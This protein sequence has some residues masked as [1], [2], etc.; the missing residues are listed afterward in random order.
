MSVLNKKM[1]QREKSI[2]KK[3]GYDSQTLQTPIF[4]EYGNF[5]KEPNKYI[6]RGIIAG[7]IFLIL[8]LLLY[9]PSWIYPKEKQTASLTTDTL[10][11][12]NMTNY[13]K[14]YP[15]ED[16]DQDGLINVMEEENETSPR[17]P[18]TDRDGLSDYAECY[19]TFTNPKK[20]DNY[21]DKQMEEKLSQEQTSVKNPFRVGNIILWAKD[22]SSR[23]HGSVVKTYN[24]YRFC[25]FKGYAEFPG[26]TVYA[27]K[28]IGEKHIPLKYKE[29][30]KAWEITDDSEVRIYDHKLEPIYKL[31]FVKKY[32][33]ISNKYIGTILSFL[34]P[35]KS[36]FLSCE[37][38]M[39]EDTY[40]NAEGSVENEIVKI[41]YDETSD[42]RFGRAFYTLE[43]L[44]NI[45][46]QIDEGR[47]LL[48]SLLS[49]SLG[50]GIIEIYGYTE[51]GD[52]LIA[53][54]QELKPIGTLAITE[55]TGQ[56]MDESGTVTVRN[57]FDFE[58]FGFNSVNGNVLSI[59]QASVIPS[60]NNAIL[61]HP[62]SKSIMTGE[63]YEGT[64]KADGEPE[65]YAWYFKLE[66]K[67]W[68]PIDLEKNKT[69]NTPTLNI[70]GTKAWNNAEVK[71]IVTFKNGDKMESEPA[72][73][74]IYGLTD[75]PKD[76]EAK[77]D[78]T[79]KFTIGTL[80]KVK[81]YKWEIS[82]DGKKWEEI[83]DN[84]TSTTKELSIKVTDKN[85]GYK[86]RC[87]ITM[88]NKK[89]QTSKE[90]AIIVK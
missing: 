40:I 29:N 4:D 32:K 57:W 16:L 68:Q 14:T 55:R 11:I 83:K 1:R 24:G 62:E 72:K 43:D 54:H 15:N 53:D 66:K 49:G 58:G 38:L 31:S 7:S 65:T 78:D 45:Y 36:Y 2:H 75:N 90:A 59:F 8:F 60:D 80:G 19:V 34:L 74:T 44:A 6:K 81:S 76:V 9:I 35:E 26:E 12:N 77:I 52:L 18:D 87:T 64:V 79:I 61:L 27:Y 71:C 22:L 47:C 20:Y 73:L 33:Y 41:D 30:E 84:K 88:E 89:T 10:M 3:T 63:M 48:A 69:G 70:K 13:L 82:K 51:T 17:Y 28:Y 46:H 37:G 23:A 21:L 50:E 86:V 67:E 5:Q 85:K 25:D 56:F 39:K 42:K